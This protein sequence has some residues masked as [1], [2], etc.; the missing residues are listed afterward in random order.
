MNDNVKPLRPNSLSELPENPIKIDPR[1]M[2]F[3]SHSQIR[4]NEKDRTVRCADPKCGAT[5]DAF[6]FLRHNA[7][8]LQ[9]AWT[10]HAYVQTQLSELNDRVAA[11]K[12]E[13]ANARKRLATLNGKLDPIIDTRGKKP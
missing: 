9:Q 4:L 11:L 12:R 8:T 13:E 2:G 5:L 6:D 7:R 1:P 10:S 3:C